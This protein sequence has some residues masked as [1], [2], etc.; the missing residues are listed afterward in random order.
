MTRTVW[1]ADKAEEL[2]PFHTR[3]SQAQAH[4]ECWRKVR[5]YT[6]QMANIALKKAKK[7]VL[8][9][10]EDG[11]KLHVYE[12]RYLQFGRHWHIG[13]VS[14]RVSAEGEEQTMTTTVAQGI[15]R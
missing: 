9:H 11:P 14:R 3:A 10:G 7:R 8:E 12:C 5:Y 1:L 6:Q 2:D 4:Q 13:H 15:G